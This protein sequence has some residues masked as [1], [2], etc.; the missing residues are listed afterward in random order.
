MHILQDM[1]RYRVF[2]FLGATLFLCAVFFQPIAKTLVG[3]SVRSALKW[4]GCGFAYRSIEFEKGRVV[5]N[6]PVLFDQAGEKSAFHARAEKASLLFDFSHF[7]KKLK[8]CL[9]IE[10]PT[11][12]LLSPCIGNGKRSGWFDL[13][14]DVRDGTVEWPG[15]ERAQFWYEKGAA[16]QVGK[17]KLRWTDSDL[18]LEAIEESSG[19][20]VDLD[21]KE[22][23]APSLQSL[24]RFYAPDPF[25]QVEIVDGT[26]S[27]SIF[28]VLKEG[29][30]SETSCRLETKNLKIKTDQ[31][32]LFSIDADCEWEGPVKGCTEGRLL[33]DFLPFAEDGRLRVSINGLN[34]ESNGSSLEGLRG[35]ISY[36]PGMGARWEIESV[37]FSRG[38]QF[39]FRWEGRGYF[40]KEMDN[41]LESRAFFGDASEVLF[42]GREQGKERSWTVNCR[43]LSSS[44]GTLLQA[45]LSTQFD[46]ASIEF[47]EGTLS[48]NAQVYL[49]EDA[50]SFWTAPHFAIE[51]A[52]F[53]A[54]DFCFSCQKTEGKA[55][56]DGGEVA[57]VSG[58]MEA[59]LLKGADWNGT[60]KW[61]G[62][63]MSLSHFTG[64]IEDVEVSLD[65]EG[66]LNCWKLNADLKG[67]LCGKVASRLALQG[68]KLQFTVE[69]GSLE[70][71]EFKGAGWF[72]NGVFA[73][74]SDEF[75]GKIDWLSR[76]HEDFDCVGRVASFEKGFFVEGNRSFYNWSLQAKIEEAKG[77]LF[78][79][80]GFENLK[81]EIF[82]EPNFLA[83]YGIEADLVIP[84]G[85]IKIESPGLRKVGSDWDFDVRCK[86]KNWDPIR[87]A[88]SYLGEKVQI[89]SK[90]SHFFGAPFHIEE[91][92]LEPNGDVARFD[93]RVEFPWSSAQAG[94]SFFKQLS[95]GTCLDLPFDGTLA[96]Q[97]HYAKEGG[98]EVSLEALNA[99]WK[100]KPIC[101]NMHGVEK[102]GLWEVDRFDC[103]DF[104]A[105]FS[106]EKEGKD[107]HIQAGK[108][109]LGEGL[110]T[111]FSGKVGLNDLTNMAIHCSFRL[112]KMEL[113]L[114]EMNSMIPIGGLEGILRGNG[115]IAYSG[116]WEADLDFSAENLKAG[117]L[118]LENQG[119]IHLYCSS[120]KGI[121]FSGLDLLVAKEPVNCKIELLQYD[122]ARSHWIFKRSHMHLPADFLAS[123]FNRGPAFLKALDPE[124][125]LDFIADF[126]CASDFS[127]LNGVMQEGFIPI[128]GAVR[129]IQNLELVW[130]KR[131]TISLDY[132]HQGNLIKMGLDIAFS[133]Q[134]EGR[135]TLEDRQN[136]LQEGERA[137]TIDWKYVENKG[138][139]IEAIEGIFGGIDASFHAQNVNRLIGS[140]RV[141]F[142]ALAPFLPPDVAV[143][144]QDLKMGK[145]YELK[146]HL[147]IDRLSCSFRGI[148]SGK[149]IDLFGYQFRTL[150]AQVDLGAEKMRIYDLKI[151]DS[152][153]TMKIDDIVLE[154]KENIPWT[155]S[156]PQIAIREF[157]PSLLQKPGEA[158]GQVGPLVVRE[159]KIVDFKGLL[160]D[161]STYM[162][163]GQLNFIN[164]FKREHTVFDIP[165]DVLSRIVGLDLDLL[166]PVRGTLSYELKDGLFRFTELKGAFSEGERSE[167]FLVSDGLSPCMDLDGNLKIFVQMKQFVLFK[168]TEA[169]L[170]SIDGTLDDPKFH[171]QKKRGFLGL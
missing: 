67:A 139:S 111:E 84:Q 143:V 124:H 150:L 56:L 140:A 35:E 57:L 170:I 145:G 51:G 149:Q 126:D 34:F 45:L 58:A 133:P 32:E 135:L 62:G 39:P 4:N 90:K 38:T 53:R 71:L 1:A 122:T 31:F 100:G 73:F 87:L 95:I 94:S 29:A 22:I 50:I 25:Q 16:N 169:F 72:E 112:E 98:S 33:G 77:N 113:D 137:L 49:K 121:F 118:E 99:S 65:I 41:W 40:H 66:A 161:G 46:C 11:V 125:D 168:L 152:S 114:F 61:E 75:H 116:K 14:V 107:F 102:E 85:R 3:V 120:E 43:S 144:F 76:F 12:S 165:S 147:A 80:T 167:F 93:G 20:K 44:M 55:S 17:L 132:I 151:S 10:S 104:S 171:L 23:K 2:G 48:A 9:N 131:G 153:G 42:E 146:G 79:E 108:G 64:K 19:W 88:G 119:P 70:G 154:G 28:L 160:D 103:A 5:F 54:G 155:I 117:P 18:C 37:G 92:D 15:L 47:L 59:P 8:G 21:L 97:I 7:P 130:D 13:Q 162:A 68:K 163:K 141:N 96:L 63:V 82:A 115:H 78:P 129:H 128:G 109:S 86:G 6:E 52:D 60:C 164:S 158:L 74:A 101:L 26:L 134:I 142:E 148:L 138:V 24:I 106:L 156:I 81:M 36:N 157:R 91:F 123:F 166:I 69:N 27:G 110:E 89:D 136:P 30:V 159:L 127:C 105:S 83:F